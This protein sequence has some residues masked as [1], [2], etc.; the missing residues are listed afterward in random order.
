M[1]NPM[2]VGIGIGSNVGDR[3]VHIRAAFQWLNHVS[4]QP[5]RSSF[6]YESLPVG[7]PPGSPPFLN[8]ACEIT[9]QGD[10]MDLLAKMKEFEKDRGR[11]ASPIRNSPRT[12]DLDMLYADNLVISTPDLVLPHPKMFERRFVMQPLADVNPALILPGTQKTVA[13]I[14][15]SL[16]E[17]NMRLFSKEK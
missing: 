4:S 15:E 6:I 5:I 10:L 2:H 16:S 3:L 14:V 8:A 1:A 13:Q 7:C 9:Y 11:V 12:L 17:E